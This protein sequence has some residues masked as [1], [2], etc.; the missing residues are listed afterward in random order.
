M[1][2]P[3][4]PVTEMELHA[5]VDG[6][7]DDAGRGRVEQWLKHNPADAAKVQEWQK[8]NTDL[9]A[10]FAGYARAL[11]SDQV[12]V[13]GRMKTLRSRIGRG[14]GAVAAAM[15]IFAAGAGAGR[16][17]I[18][19]DTDGFSPLTLAEALPREA[20]SA[21]MIYASDVRRPVEVGADQEEHLVRW[22]GKRL[23]YPLSTPDLTEKGFRLLGG[24][25]VPSR[26]K[27][28][29]LFM[30]EN[31]IGERLTLLIGRNDANRDTSFRFASEGSIDTFYWIDGPL[32]YAVTGEISAGK[33]RDVAD[34]VYRQL[35]APEPVSAN[36]P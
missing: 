28:G 11:P 21:F 13:A 36:R 31:Q 10:M 34:E 30:Y 35:F 7:I 25:L 33:L 12:M 18:A 17:T 2:S 16:L 14:L 3:N 27:P 26:G 20:Q 29:A 6:Q 9:K 4:D 23:D 22:L 1:K 19:Y 5:Y 24:R 15:L 32:G 8:Q